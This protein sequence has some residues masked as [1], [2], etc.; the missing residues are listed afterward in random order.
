MY[1]YKPKQCSIVDPCIPVR[2]G[3]FTK[4]TFLLIIVA[5]DY[6]EILLT[7]CDGIVYF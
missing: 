6:A 4:K 5:K 2:L 7:I 3:K 1:N